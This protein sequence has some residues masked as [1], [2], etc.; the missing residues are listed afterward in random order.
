MTTVSRQPEGIPSGGQF[1]ATTHS[2]PAVTLGLPAP[3]ST[4]GVPTDHQAAKDQFEARAQSAW[5]TMVQEAHP[6]AA[7][8]FAKVNYAR[9][10]SSARDVVIY[11]GQGEDVP[12]NREESSAFT[13][14]FDPFW[15]ID[16]HA[17]PETDAIFVKDSGVFSLASI[18]DRWNEV[19]S[20]P[21]PSNDPFSHLT[22][23]DKA[24]AQVGYAQQI[25][26][27]AV[28][29]YVGDLSAKLLAINPE[30]GRLYVNRTTDVEQ[31]TTFTLDRVED[32]HGNVGDVDV[33]GLADEA[34]QDNYLD[35]HVDYDEGSDELYINLDPNN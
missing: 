6:E 28:S 8:A 17:T 30:F 10:N 7:Y 16:Q 26:A 24:R 12:V 25:N 35:P 22:G 15:N 31:G 23:M 2:E 9:S 18:H 3:T 27:E 11:D 1:A 29:A 32:I 33:T 4:D 5:A 19:S 21:E 34:F 13:D 20:S 14:S